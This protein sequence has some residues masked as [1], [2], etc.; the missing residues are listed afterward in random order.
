MSDDARGE[1]SGALLR[2]ALF[3]AIAVLIGADVVSD[4]GEGAGLAHIALEAVVLGLACVGV[5]LGW[6]R[7]LQA[8]AD[9]ARLG[10]DLARTRAQADAW[11]RENEALVRGL[12]MAIERQFEEWGLTGAEA[13]VGLLLLKGLSL[14][15][16]AELR[17][18]SERTTREQARAIYRKGGLAGRA[19]LSAFFLEDLLAA[20]EPARGG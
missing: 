7:H 13:E 5:L 14:Q 18:T 19:E 20:P 15:E 11:R 3:G 17:K 6:R 1:P 12:A 9:L 10:A 4:Y 8:R 16:I 2:V